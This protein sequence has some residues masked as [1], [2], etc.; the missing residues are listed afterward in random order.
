VQKLETIGQLTGGVAHDFNNLLTPIMGSLD[1]IRRRVPMDERMGRLLGGALESAERAKTL[2]ARLLAFA[3]RQALEARPVDLRALVAGM[4][5]LVGRS[6]GPAIKVT[7]AVPEDLP[8]AKVD[9]AQLELALLNLAV[10]ARDAMPSG[11]DLTIAAREERVEEQNGHGL[12]SGRFLVLSVADT[13]L[14]MDD[15]TLARAVEPFLL[16]EGHRPGHRP[17]PFDGSRSRGAVGRPARAHQ[18]ARQG[19]TAAIWLPVADGAAPV[20]AAPAVE[21]SPARRAANVLLVDDEELVRTGTAEMLRD[22]GYAVTEASGGTQA[23]ELLHSGLVPDVVVTDYL[24]T[25]HEW[26]RAHPRAAT[27]AASNAGAPD[28]R[29]ARRSVTVRQAISHYWPSPSGRATWPR[30]STSC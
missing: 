21:T 13:G 29:V 11:G 14:G 28:H 20:I 24:M 19:T 3:R 26:D 17:G 8:P 16:D 5:D 10:N 30:A 15:E 25:R 9:P 12:A 23:L 22:L 7:V 2:V 27:L 18:P 1:I 6:L 4:T